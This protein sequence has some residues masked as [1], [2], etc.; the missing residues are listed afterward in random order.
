MLLLRFVF[1]CTY[2][3]ALIQKRTYLGTYIHTHKYEL[4]ISFPS[5]YVMDSNWKTPRIQC[6]ES[7]TE[8]SDL[9]LNASNSL[10][11]DPQMHRSSKLPGTKREHRSQ[12]P[13]VSWVQLRT[14][15][16]NC[17]DLKTGVSI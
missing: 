13:E 17:H 14:N 10:M 12:S 8:Y 16:K 11:H 6:C 9:G 15:R 5:D 1:L 2:P 7:P 4:C 3:S